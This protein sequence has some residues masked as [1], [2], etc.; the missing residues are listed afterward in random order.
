MEQIAIN[1]RLFGDLQIDSLEAAVQRDQFVQFGHQM[2]IGHLS[3]LRT[4][5][6]SVQIPYKLIRAPAFLK[7]RRHLRAPHSKIALQPI[8]PRRISAAV[9]P[10]QSQIVPKQTAEIAL[11]QPLNATA[12]ALRGTEAFSSKWAT[13]EMAAE[14]PICA[15][16][17]P[18]SPGS[19]SCQ[20][21]CASNSPPSTAAQ[22]PTGAG[23]TYVHGPAQPVP[24]PNHPVM[25]PYPTEPPP[26]ASPFEGNNILKS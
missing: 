18:S 2:G 14:A 25:P 9:P 16:S 19:S 6:N 20:P 15:P 5:D 4:L 12:E 1:Q 3:A 13:T 23:G 8:A 11:H 24:T 10:N 22:S 21:I 7:H 17:H 26:V